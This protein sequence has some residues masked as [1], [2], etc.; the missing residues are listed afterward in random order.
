MTPETIGTDELLEKSQ[1]LKRAVKT[2]GRPVMH[3]RELMQKLGA[4]LG[5]FLF[6]LVGLVVT[7][8][9]IRLQIFEG[10]QQQ[11]FAAMS[12]LL[13]G[14]VILFSII[15]SFLSLWNAFV[16]TYVELQASKLDIAELTDQIRSL[17]GSL[18]TA[19]PPEPKVVVHEEVAI[20]AG[21][22]RVNEPLARA[23]KAVAAAAPSETAEMVTALTEAAFGNMVSG[24]TAEATE[25]VHG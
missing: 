18:V 19:A 25:R 1:I 21:T 7:L 5:V 23:M 6:G 10:P 2:T 3:P 15:G 14:A 22:Y 13:S 11:A 20:L 12:V 9:L 24:P 4:I 16:S 8:V 17:I